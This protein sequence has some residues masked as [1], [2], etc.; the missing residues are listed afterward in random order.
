ML[1]LKVTDVSSLMQPT[2][3]APKS[4]IARRIRSAD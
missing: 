3:G 4:A 1:G 2:L